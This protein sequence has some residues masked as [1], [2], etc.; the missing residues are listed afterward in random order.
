MR[1][2]SDTILSITFCRFASAALI[3]TGEERPFEASLSSPPESSDS[4]IAFSA[5]SPLRV[6]RPLR[7]RRF[8]VSA[9]HFS[10]ARLFRGERRSS[11]A[12]GDSSAASAAGRASRGED[13]APRIPALAAA[14]ALRA[15]EKDWPGGAIL[16]PRASEDRRAAREGERF[17]CAS[18][19]IADTTVSVFRFFV[20]SDRR[21]AGSA[22]ASSDRFGRFGASAAAEGPSPEPRRPLSRSESRRGAEPPFFA[23]PLSDSP[24]PRPRLFSPKLFAPLPAAP[25]PAFCPDDALSGVRSAA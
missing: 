18:R 7:R 15:R 13:S 21:F 10:S 1:P 4:T 16:L 9:A 8:G 22:A 23:R 5:T 6:R 19:V 11:A 20:V 12:G 17:F 25:R 3:A 24:S 2:S 14:G